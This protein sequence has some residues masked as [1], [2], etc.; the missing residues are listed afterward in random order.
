[1]EMSTDQGAVQEPYLT[2][3]VVRLNKLNARLQVVAEE[4][5]VM[6][7]RLL[8]PIPPSLDAKQPSATERVAS[9]TVGELD[10]LVGMIDSKIG[11][12]EE[13]HQELMNAL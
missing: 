2:R 3:I 1:M 12:L 11:R 5:E 7:V 13:S 9:G 4:Y 8:G 6:R 10:D